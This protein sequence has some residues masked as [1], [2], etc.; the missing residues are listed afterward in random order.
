LRFYHFSG[1]DSGAGSNMVSYYVPD[2]NHVVHEIWSWYERQLVENEQETLGNIPW[3]YSRFDNG[4]P[5]TDQMRTVY[6]SR[7]DLQKHFPDP[8]TVQRPDGGFHWW[9][10]NQYLPHE[11][12]A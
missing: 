9:W 12:K 2:E 10:F 1:Y 6:K 5:V 11:A 3:H 7:W 8:F 4:Q